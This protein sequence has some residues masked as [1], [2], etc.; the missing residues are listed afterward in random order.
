MA[1]QIIEPKT[2][3]AGL[4]ENWRSDLISG[5]LIFLI[6]LPLSLGIALGMGV[7]PV[8]GLFSAMVGGIIVSRISRSTVPIVGPPAGLIV[9]ILAAVQSLGEG[10]ALAGYR[11]TLA[12]IVIAAV[13]QI[14][15]G[16]FKAGR[17]TAYFPSS[18]VHGMLASIG[19][20]IMI[21]Q[22]HTM[23]GVKPEPG[24]LLSVAAQVPHTILH[25]HPEIVIIGLS[26]LILLIVWSSITNRYIKMIPAP[27][28]V[29]MIGVAF[30]NLFDLSHEHVIRVIEDEQ[31]LEQFKVGPEFLVTV[32]ADLADGV[33]FPD[34]SKLWTGA[35]WGAV[36]SICLVGSL[37]SILSQVAVDKLDPYKRQSDLNRGQT[38]IGV[39]NLISGLI[40]G[41]PMIYEIVRSSAN[42]NNGAKT[43]WANF[44]HGLFML[45]FVA[46]FPFLIH[47][48]PLASLAALL[49][50]TGYRLASPKEFAK[51]LT[52]GKEQLVL[53]LITIFGVLATDLLEGVAI[54]I[55][56]K[57][58]FH[59]FRGVSLK[60][61]L[62]IFY[63]IEPQGSNSFYIKISGAAVF[64]NFISLKV[65]LS[66]I[67]PKKN[68]VF[69]F[70]ES[71]F[72]DHTVMESVE[73]FCRVYEDAGG[74]CEVHGFDDHTPYGNHPLA[75]RKR[76]RNNHT[77]EVTA[78]E[79]ADRNF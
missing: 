52:I 19:I 27:L 58:V 43:N 64:S 25:P 34:F 3:F 46:M 49:V 51:T 66:E 22:I 53:F 72:V 42:I 59:L 54:G 15:L 9:V 74:T 39:G 11:Y 38:A 77:A 28:L 23:F 57:L 76:A 31:L 68:V 45:S 69:D 26:G 16:L 20:I 71:E 44:F 32:P 6:A 5:F 33:T 50:Y 10:D 17:L 13:I 78:H 48:I 56:A 40:G 8:A 24:S 60:N 70:S 7:P 36:V 67:P 62:K 61:L 18:V 2:G 73:D 65:A 79:P 29:V 4:R 14:L 41:V 1:T 35:F 75:A 37:E 12:A 63:E 55:A 21:K 30:G 47:R